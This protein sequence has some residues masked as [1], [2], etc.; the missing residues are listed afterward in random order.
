MKTELIERF[1]DTFKHP[2]KWAWQYEPSIPLV[3]KRYKPGKGLLIYASAENLSWFNSEPAPPR[4]LKEKAW[5]RYRICYE[6]EGRTS[7]T[8]FPDVGIQP[9]TDGGLFAA[10]LFIAQKMGLPTRKTPRA[11]LETIAVSNWC[12]YSIRAENN[13]DYIKNLPKLTESLAFRFHDIRHT[14]ASL[15]LQQGESLHYV[16]EQMGH[17]SIQTTVDVYGHIVP[18]SNRNAVNKLDDEEAAEIRLVT[19]AG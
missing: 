12:K 10:G 7:K 11:F 3:G 19:T 17:A 4:F 15:L 1:K 18:G 6:H 13:V 2:P 9:V 8:F 5:N 14:F 16:K